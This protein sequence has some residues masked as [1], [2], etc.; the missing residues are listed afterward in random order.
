MEL[1]LRIVHLPASSIDYL[2]EAMLTMGVGAE[3][4]GSSKVWR[5]R[6]SSIMRGGFF[7][8]VPYIVCSFCIHNSS[9]LLRLFLG[10]ILVLYITCLIQIWVIPQ[11]EDIVQFLVKVEGAR[12]IL[13]LLALLC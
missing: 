8:V 7:H 12:Q 1:D 9:D 5:R 11:S 4:N 3:N 2:H 13:L 6:R 10:S